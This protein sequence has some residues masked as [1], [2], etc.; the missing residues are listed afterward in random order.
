MS[1]LSENL[2]PGN[3]GKIFVTNAKDNTDLERIKNRILSLKGI[4]DVSLNSEVFP[5][6]LT[7]FT[8]KL[9]KVKDIEDVVMTTGFHAI[10]KGLFQ[11]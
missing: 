5:K 3:H 1:L 8:T 11:V 9:V 4:K 2:I 7:I 6:E 10:P